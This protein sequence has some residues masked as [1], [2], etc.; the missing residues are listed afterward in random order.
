MGHQVRDNLEFLIDPPACSV[1][2]T[3]AQSLATGSATVLDA[4]SENFDNDAMHSNVTNN[5]R[6]TVQTAGRYLFYTRVE[7]AANATGVR[8]IRFNKNGVQLAAAYTG[9]PCRCRDHTDRYDGRR[10]CGRFGLLR[11]DREP[12]IGRKP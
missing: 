10:C 2:N 8:E 1:F 4:N 3:V 12:N 6:I 9:P 5:S 11:S 7:F